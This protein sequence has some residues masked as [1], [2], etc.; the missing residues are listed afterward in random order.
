[1]DTMILEE[2]KKPTKLLFKPPF[3]NFM[4][5]LMDIFLV[6]N[7]RPSNNIVSIFL[8]VCYYNYLKLYIF[9]N[10][11]ISVMSS[12]LTTISDNYN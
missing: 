11:N 5:K 3:E 8:N 2:K 1:M 12:K 7:F 10:A 9:K 6:K 4:K